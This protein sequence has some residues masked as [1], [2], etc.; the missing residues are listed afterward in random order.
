[1]TWE[2]CLWLVSKWAGESTYFNGI[3]VIENRQ[4]NCAQ[5][6]WSDSV[7]FLCCI[8]DKMVLCIQ[9]LLFH[10]TTGACQRTVRTAGSSLCLLGRSTQGKMLTLTCSP[11]KKTTTCTKSSVCLVYYLVA[12]KQTTLW[13]NLNDEFRWCV[14]NWSF[15][16]TLQFTMSSLN[17][18][19]ITTTYGKPLFSNCSR[20]WKLQICYIY[21]TLW[22][23]CVCPQWESFAFHS[24]W[25][26]IPLWAGGHLEHMVRRTGSGR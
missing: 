24:R 6:S 5:H 20:F 19:M 11:R 16:L 25:P 23:V 1:M 22:C 8:A 18:L 26:W 15:V 3:T 12:V 4:H 7:L 21:Y 2:A 17:A 13:A 14:I 10:S 9:L